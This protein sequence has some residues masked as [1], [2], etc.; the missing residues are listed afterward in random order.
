MNRD[1]GAAGG[2]LAKELLGLLPCHHRVTHD[3][4]AFFVAVLDGVEALHACTVA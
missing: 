3:E 4:V 1:R 2:K